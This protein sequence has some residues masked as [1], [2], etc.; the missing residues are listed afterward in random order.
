MAREILSL[1][2]AQRPDFTERQVNFCKELIGIGLTRLTIVGLVCNTDVQKL[3]H[4]QI[5]AGQ[6]L[7]ESCRKELGYGIMDARRAQSPWTISAVRSAAKQL[8][9]RIK[10]A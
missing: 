2:E 1:S 8:S 3:N 7:I 4:A 6:R 9:L 10:I 5:N